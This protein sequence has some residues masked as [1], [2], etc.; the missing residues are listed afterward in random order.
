MG[1]CMLLHAAAMER[2]Q[3][4]F[5]GTLEWYNL[6]IEEM[7]ELQVPNLFSRYGRR[8]SSSAAPRMKLLW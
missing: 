3:C 6:T 7:V 8:M 4:A 5:V 1:T 2:L